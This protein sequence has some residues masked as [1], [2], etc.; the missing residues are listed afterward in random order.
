MPLSRLLKV[1]TASTYLPKALTPMLMEG[2]FVMV[3]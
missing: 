2:N 3:H 1:H